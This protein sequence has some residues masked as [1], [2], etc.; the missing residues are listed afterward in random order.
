MIYFLLFTP[1]KFTRVCILVVFNSILS[2]ESTKDDP[3]FMNIL[4]IQ[5][6]LKKKYIFEQ[7]VYRLSITEILYLMM[8]NEMYTSSKSWYNF[9]KLIKVITVRKNNIHVRNRTK[10]NGWQIHQQKKHILENE[11]NDHIYHVYEIEITTS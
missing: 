5:Y 1:L 9:N 11:W 8:S 10:R 2:R 6:L 7:F 3:C 4:N